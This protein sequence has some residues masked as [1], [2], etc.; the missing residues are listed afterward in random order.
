MANARLGKQAGGLIFAL[1]IQAL[2]VM[3][4]L[5]SIA[6]PEHARSARETILLLRR[7]VR[8]PL[9]SVIDARTPE[10]NTRPGALNPAPGLSTPP[11][12][13]EAAPVL[14]GLGESLEN[15]A[16][17]KLDRL[18]PQALA[19]CRREGRL[20]RPAPPDAY[21]LHEP[22]S[23]SKDAAHWAAELARRKDIRVPPVSP[24]SRRRCC[25][26]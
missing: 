20:V 21:L 15:C 10:P 14:P 2:F 24:L 5:S 23:Q 13:P 22:P 6:K 4:L 11:A 25:A 12:L 3:V 16:P 7:A 18:S 9:P 26:G 17:E 19:Q 8:L 1:G